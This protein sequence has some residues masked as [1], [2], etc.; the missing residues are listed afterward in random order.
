[1]TY[2]PVWDDLSQFVD[3]DDYAVVAEITLKDGTTRAINV[4]FDNPAAVPAAGEY[5][6]DDM[7]IR[8]TGIE[9]EMVG[10]K[11][12]DAVVIKHKAAE[13][14]LQ[15]VGSYGILTNPQPDGTG[16]ASVSLVAE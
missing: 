10:I 15:T 1:M 3:T 13:G 11:R 6:Q 2:V 4:I 12:G 16:M 8:M 9:T 5:K 7:N 14:T